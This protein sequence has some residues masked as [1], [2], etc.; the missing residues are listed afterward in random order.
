MESNWLSNS[1]SDEELA[2]TAPR[3]IQLVW[4]FV[5]LVWDGGLGAE[6]FIDQE[7]GTAKVCDSGS[8]CSVDSGSVKLGTSEKEGSKLLRL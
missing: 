4:E 3:F 8:G 2:A 6:A 1:D 5:R 7:T